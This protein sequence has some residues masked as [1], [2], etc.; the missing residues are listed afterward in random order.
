MERR[1]YRTRT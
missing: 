1:T